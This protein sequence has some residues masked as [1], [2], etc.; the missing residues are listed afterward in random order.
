MRRNEGYGRQ[1]SHLV[2]AALLTSYFAQ[3]TGSALANHAAYLHVSRSDAHSS[4]LS[5]VPQ[6]SSHAQPAFHMSCVVASHE[7]RSPPAS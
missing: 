2:V 1:V 4:L 7:D 5:E 3:D 6:L